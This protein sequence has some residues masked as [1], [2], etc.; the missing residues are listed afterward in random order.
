MSKSIFGWKYCED[1]DVTTR[2]KSY[3][4]TGNVQNKTLKKSH[5]QLIFLNAFC[6]WR[7]NIPKIM[8]KS[9][10]FWENKLKKNDSVY[11]NVI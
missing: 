3:Y 2:L 6:Q 4:V 9:L 7:K 11:W 8:E 5:R 1:S 10:K